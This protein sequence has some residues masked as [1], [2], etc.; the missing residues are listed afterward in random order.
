MSVMI[1]SEGLIF[2]SVCVAKDMPL[3]EVEADVNRLR[4]T[5]IS[6]PW[7]ISDEKKFANGQSHPLPCDQDDSHV[8]YLLNC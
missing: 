4:P 7:K 5:G 1:Y 8:H 2:L 6:S 3:E